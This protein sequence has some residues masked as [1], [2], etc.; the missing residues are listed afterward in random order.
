LTKQSCERVQQTLWWFA[1]R[2]VE[3]RQVSLIDI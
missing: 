1:H 3:K 2:I